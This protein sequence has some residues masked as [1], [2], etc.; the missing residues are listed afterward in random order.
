[1]LVGAGISDL[2]TVHGDTAAAS[3]TYTPD[4]ILF[5]IESG[6]RYFF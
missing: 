5:N 4:K 6:V 3:F 2:L 1:V